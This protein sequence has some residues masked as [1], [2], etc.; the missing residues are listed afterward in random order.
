MQVI[1]ACAFSTCAFAQQFRIPQMPAPPPMRFVTRSERS[2]LDS[3]RDPK[4]RLRATVSI[5]EAHLQRAEVFT[6][7]KKFDEAAAEV[8]EYLGLIGDMRSFVATLNHDKNATRDIYRHF[9][10][11]VRPHIP[12]LAVIRRDT[13]ATYAGN[14]KDAEEYIKDTRSEALDSFYGHS[15]LREPDTPD[16]IKHP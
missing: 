4:A 5:A 12:R 11:A 3:A 2:E 13:P 14:I 10:I 9:E 8:G 15:V 1:A 6:T 7:N 16:A